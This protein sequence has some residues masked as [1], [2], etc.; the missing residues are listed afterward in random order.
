MRFYLCAFLALGLAA[1]GG[2]SDTTEPQNNAMITATGTSFSPSTVTIKPGGSVTWRFQSGGPHNV[3][4]DGTAPTGGDI[5]D[6]STGDVSR[7]FGTAG[8]YYYTCTNHDGMTGNV[9]VQSSGGGG[10]Y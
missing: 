8:T 5:A 6:T 2:D 1:C 9:Y 3:T 10:G 4:W 7:T